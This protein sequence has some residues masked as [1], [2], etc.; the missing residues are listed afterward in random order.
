MN[1]YDTAEFCQNSKDE[2]INRHQL[3]DR[4]HPPKNRTAPCRGFSFRDILG[5]SFSETNSFGKP[6]YNLV[7][8]D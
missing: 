8:G 7:D 3:E 2:K 1:E 4:K 6:P 5:H